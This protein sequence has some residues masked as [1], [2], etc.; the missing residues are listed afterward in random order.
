MSVKDSKAIL[1]RGWKFPVSPDRNL[2]ISISEFEDN[3]RESILIIL[4]TKKGERLMRP[5]FGCDINDFV[6]ES[7][8]SLTLGNIEV[9]I[10][11][12]L[13]KFEPRIELI[14]IN[15]S[16][17]KINEGFLGIN[18]TY[19]VISTNNKFNLVYPFYIQEGY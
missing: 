19:R 13:T 15:I 7:I 9:S 17:D 4:G 16:I 14:D 1:G 5:D 10:T 2:E 12:A 3:I 18:I 6:F 11:E 8:S